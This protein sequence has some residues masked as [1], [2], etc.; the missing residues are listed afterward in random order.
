MG[1][2]L[3]R[4]FQKDIPARINTLLNLEINL[5]LRNNKTIHGVLKK[6]DNDLLTMDGVMHEKHTVKVEEITE[7]IYDKEAAY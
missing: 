3:I 1:K 2:R 5:V 6:V 4:I 7:I